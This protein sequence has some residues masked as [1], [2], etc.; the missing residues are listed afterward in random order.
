MTALCNKFNSFHFII[1]IHYSSN[2]VPFLVVSSGCGTG[3]RCHAEQ[4]AGLGG[5][6]VAGA[7]EAR[8]EARRHDTV[9]LRM[10]GAYAGGYGEILLIW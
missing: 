10:R 9:R 7:G 5:L 2:Y 4:R 1:F 3:V 8:G 6:A